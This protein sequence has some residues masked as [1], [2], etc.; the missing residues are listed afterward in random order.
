MGHSE[1]VKIAKSV[2]PLQDA[3]L[4]MD[5]AYSGPLPQNAT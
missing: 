4:M 1:P 5:N 2:K 3:L